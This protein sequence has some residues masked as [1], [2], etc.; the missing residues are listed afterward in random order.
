MV[1][2]RRDR[3]RILQTFS[4]FTYVTAHSPTLPSIYLRHNSFSNPS[5]A[6]PM[7]QLI[8]QPFFRLSYVTGFSLTSPG[9]PPMSSSGLTPCIVMKND[10]ILYHHMSSFSPELWTKVVL[11]ERAVV[12]SVYRLSLTAQRGKVLPYECHMPQ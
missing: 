8:L 7:S 4:H 2:W 12:C 3:N 10:G 6:S 11:Q 1:L 5:V 9:E